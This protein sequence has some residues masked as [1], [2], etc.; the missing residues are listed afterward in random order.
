MLIE[1]RRAESLPRLPLVDRAD[2]LTAFRLALADAAHGR[3]RTVVVA[4]FPA[5][6]KTAL[7]ERFGADA[8]SQGF[9]VL[10]AVGARTE[11]ELHLGVVGQL[12]RTVTLPPDIA[13]RG[14][15]LLAADV[16][17]VRRGGEETRAE[18]RAL[19]DLLLEVA[20]RLGPVVIMVDDVHFADDLS[21][22]VLLYLGRRLAGGRVLL[23]V[24]E[25]V[26]PPSTHLPFRAQITRLPHEILLVR[27][28]APDEVAQMIRNFTGRPAALPAARRWHQLTGG[29]PL[30]VLA[31]AYDN[32]DAG[33]EEPLVVGSAYQ[34][35]MLV[36][37]HR[38]EPEVLLVARAVAI[39]GAQAE[40]GPVA[41]V[42]GLAPSV[43]AATIQVLED[44]GLLMKGC[45]RHEQGAAAVVAAIGEQ[46]EASLRLRA[47]EALH[48]RGAGPAEISGQLVAAGAV[49]GPWAV[50]VLRQAAVQA[51]ADDNADFTVAALE[52]AVAA[53]TDDQQRM[54]L[55]Q[56]L[57][58][59]LWRVNPAAA[60]RRLE[61]LQQA[62]HERR[63]AP[64]N[65]VALVRH[66]L[67][68]G[69]LSPGT[70]LLDDVRSVC[71]HAPEAIGPEAIGLG[72]FHQWIYGPR[73][74]ENDLCSSSL[75]QQGASGIGS[76]LAIALSRATEF[77]H[78]QTGF[79][80]R[81]LM[82]LPG[83]LKL[84]DSTLECVVYTMILLLH[85]G[86]V[87]LAARW[88]TTLLAEAT[89]RGTTTWQALLTALH[90]DILLR[91]G[92]LEEAATRAEAALQLLSPVSW[93]VI[94][95]LP[96]A[97]LITANTALGRHESN[98]LLLRRHTV[99]TAAGDTLLG[100]RYLRARGYHRLA[101]NRVVEAL[102]DFD[103]CGIRMRAWHI[104][105]PELLPWRTDLA[106]V[107]LL[108]GDTALA[109][110]LAREELQLCRRQRSRGI[111]TRVLAACSDLRERP[112]LLHTAIDALQE[113]DDQL[114]L[115]SALTQ[116]SRV[117][118]E[119]GDFSRARILARSADHQA[120]PAGTAAEVG[121][122]TPVIGK[123]SEQQ[124]AAALSDAELR[125]ARLAAHGHTNREIS[126]RLSIT[127]STVEQHLT[128]VY[129]K[130]EVTARADLPDRLYAASGGRRP[131][132]N[133]VSST[134]EN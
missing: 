117:Y 20:D 61:P 71:G 2:Q 97:V 7:L 46:E 26:L 37:L 81:D 78:G 107:H 22:Q 39:L 69:A 108:S 59:A 58:Q 8:V 4:G 129:R 11:R 72:I 35:A 17:P 119:L 63:L 16:P 126:R 132:R 47:A 110:N 5:C 130:L 128:R 89:A 36:C 74:L 66:L 12:F 40:A 120:S 77:F 21:A 15:Q 90:A 112:R 102:V 131:V 105:L 10:Y 127:V 114:E 25:P 43:V 14:R 54:S 18:A 1:A 106:Q 111:A 86:E 104:D 134:P 27:P 60:A 109:R 121:Q 88:C 96:L 115:A 51:L 53:C 48:E 24:S 42:A 118:E 45:F 123:R 28:L 49:P 98:E 84:D 103:E 95:T 122:I 93:G 125:V 57:A 82:D 133:G 92:V 30:L 9:A 31:L 79:D 73:K 50:A 80:A 113:C 87:D 29:N 32:P 67:W 68:Q 65:A 124:H 100:L 76:G 75:V 91:K 3:G 83:R 62:L 64:A 19:G 56:L 44:S 52:L 13:E 101:A 6:G 34:Q 85:A 70:R 41:L 99:P 94:I 116:L 38:C 33:A 23:V 55:T